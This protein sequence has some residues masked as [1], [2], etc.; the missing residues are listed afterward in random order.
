MAK[1]R[2]QIFVDR[3][4]KVKIEQD[5]SDSNYLNSSNKGLNAGLFSK[6][7]RG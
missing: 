3:Q 1:A 2:K 4:Q 7:S 6:K 5:I